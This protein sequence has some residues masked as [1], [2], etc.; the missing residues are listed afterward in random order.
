MFSGLITGY[1]RAFRCS[2]M[3]R[4]SHLPAKGDG[5]SES[6]NRNIVLIKKSLIGKT[7]FE[8]LFYTGEFS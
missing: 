3:L 7:V 1:D 4:G 2:V 5:Q 8:W 6:I